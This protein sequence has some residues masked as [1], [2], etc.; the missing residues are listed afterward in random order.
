MSEPVTIRILERDFTVGVASG[1]RD[2]LVAAASLVDARMR[3]IRGGNR[4][5]AIDQVAVLAALDLAHEFL[6]L[7]ARLDKRDAALAET[8]GELNRKLDGLFDSAR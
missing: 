6:Q 3:E 1:E 8:L 4:M 2:G 5:A 7:K